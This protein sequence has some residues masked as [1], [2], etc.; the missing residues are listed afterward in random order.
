MVAKQ[1]AVKERPIFFS[2]EMCRA[3]IAGK[4]TVTRRLIDMAAEFP[5]G[6]RMATSDGLAVF[7]RDDCTLVAKKPRWAAGDV[8][9]VRESFYD[10]A[11]YAEIGKLHKDRYVYLADGVKAGWKAKPSIFMPR[12]ACR[13]LLLVAS[14]LPERLQEI[15]RA[16]VLREGI[17]S[18]HLDKNDK[19]FDYRDV[20][21][22]TFSELWD[23]INPK[24]K[25]ASNPWVWRVEF[26]SQQRGV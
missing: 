1:T 8:L 5:A 23:K 9:W 18:E 12:E 13:L 25:F 6:S 20:P 24:D 17:G 7:M 10:R 16:E 26:T 22:I 3:I 11:D 4:K 14:V 15:T 21:G 19:F 2:G